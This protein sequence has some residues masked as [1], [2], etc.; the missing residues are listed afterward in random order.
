[1]RLGIAQRGR[2]CVDRVGAED[3]VVLVP[4]GRAENEF[5]VGPC[6]ELDRLARR[7]ESRQVAVP[8]FIGN[9]HSAGCDGGPQD[10]MASWGAHSASVRRPSGAPRD[11]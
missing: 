4:D 10:D 7:L 3:E 8:Q 5:R 1:V 9:R 6:L 2:R 11:S